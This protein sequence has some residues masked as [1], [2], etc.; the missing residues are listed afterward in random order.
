MDF[1]L[2]V[3]ASLVAGILLLVAGSVVSSQFRG[4]VTGIL[5]RLLSIDIECVYPNKAS[6][7]HDIKAELTRAR[8]VMIF[9]GRGNELQSEVFAPMLRKKAAAEYPAVSILLPTTEYPPPGQCDWT[10]QR[11]TEL[12]QFDNAF[13]TGLLRR[14]IEISVSFFEPH[15]AH[16]AVTLRRF[17]APHIGRIVVTDRYAYYTPYRDDAP[18]SE[19]TVYKF[20]RDGPM[21][22]NLTR[23]FEQIWHSCPPLPP[24][25]I[26]PNGVSP[27]ASQRPHTTR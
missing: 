25:E 15:V 2:G 21:Y 9:A 6:A 17:S 10:L 12:A 19:S 27:N 16:G 22:D 18:P 3:L 20:R 14:Q 24:I 8:Q 26:P 13:G 4:L 5:S 1:L 7:H 23:L 11:E